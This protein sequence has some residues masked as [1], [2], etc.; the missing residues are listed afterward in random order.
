MQARLS[1]PELQ[2]ECVFDAKKMGINPFSL[3]LIVKKHPQKPGLMHDE[4]M[5][6]SF[7]VLE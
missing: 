1:Y 3:K 4:K 6:A 5:E 2:I 7:Y